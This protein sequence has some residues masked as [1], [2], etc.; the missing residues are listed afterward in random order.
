MGFAFAISA[1][2]RPFELLFER[3]T[4][5]QGRQQFRMFDDLHSKLMV[6]LQDFAD[7][8]DK[9]ERSIEKYGLER[10]APLPPTRSFVC[11][12]YQLCN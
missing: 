3:V 2:A 6:L 8:M 7:R 11:E 12:R 1:C 4:F 10:I 9:F 5:F